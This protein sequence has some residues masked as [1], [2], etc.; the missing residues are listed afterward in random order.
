MN[1]EIWEMNHEPWKFPF[2]KETK[3]VKGNPVWLSLIDMA[4][5]IRLAVTNMVSKGLTP[6]ALWTFLCCILTVRI[7]PVDSIDAPDVTMCWTRCSSGYGSVSI[8]DALSAV[9]NVYWYGSPE[10]WFRLSVFEVTSFCERLWSFKRHARVPDSLI[11]EWKVPFR[12]RSMRETAVRFDQ[13]CSFVTNIEKFY[14]L[15]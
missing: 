12:S 5:H 14:R 9:T 6:M 1:Y 3:V 13:L 8:I 2:F 10:A 11:R 7:A 4:M 15:S